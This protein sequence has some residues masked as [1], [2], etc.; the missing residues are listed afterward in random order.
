MS[1]SH[2]PPSLVWREGGHLSEEAIV[3]LADDQDILPADARAHGLACEECARRMGES[4]LLSSAVAGSL[5][6]LASAPAPKP[7]VQA[8]R[9]SAPMPLWALLFGVGFVT[10]GALPFLLGIGAWLPSAALL[11]QRAAPLFLHGLV[12]AFAGLSGEALPRALVSVV[13]LAVLMMSAFAVSR[14][15]PREGVAQ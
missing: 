2:L 9:S 8:Q 1:S 10:A 7:A 4:A 11:L 14:L 12:S 15:A 6:D 3:A 13:S 5:V